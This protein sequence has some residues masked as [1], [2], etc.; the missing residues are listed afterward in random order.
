M[1]FPRQPFSLF[2]FE[3]LLNLVLADLSL[4]IR[5]AGLPFLFWAL[6]LADGFWPFLSTFCL[7]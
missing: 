4:V 3:L 7:P 1:A 5:W 2:F 6:D